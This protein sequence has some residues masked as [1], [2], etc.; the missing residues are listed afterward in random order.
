M[1]PVVGLEPTW[2]SPCDFE[3]HASTNS[4]TPAPDKDELAE[5]QC[6]QSRQKCKPALQ[7]LIHNISIHQPLLAMLKGL[8]QGGHHLKP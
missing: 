7:Q 6:S 1:V 8:R 2:I 5:Y 3:S 4:A